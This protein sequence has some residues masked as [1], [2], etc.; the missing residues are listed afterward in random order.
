MK[1]NSTYADT[2]KLRNTNNGVE[3]DAEILEYKP[4]KMLIVSVNRSVKVSLKHNGKAYVGNMA[5]I[6]FTS[7]G[8]K[9]TIK[10]TGR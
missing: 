5:G 10:Y 7:Q 1:N 4:G 8:P 6:E 3:I 9:E 2:C